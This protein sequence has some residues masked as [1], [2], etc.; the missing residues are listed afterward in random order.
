M[1][2]LSR[3]PEYPA[4]GKTSEGIALWF[5]RQYTWGSPTREPGDT[6]QGFR[7]VGP[8]GLEDGGWF[9]EGMLWTNHL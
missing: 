8:C 5:T 6:W 7:P 2:S 1:D 3:I 9:Q 4:Y